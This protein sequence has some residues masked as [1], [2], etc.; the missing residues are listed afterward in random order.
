[1]LGFR[2]IQIKYLPRVRLPN[3]FSL[4]YLVNLEK[5]KS[6]TNLVE[7]NDEGLLVVSSHNSQLDNYR[8]AF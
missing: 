7:N 3:L 5:Y 1:M 8:G 2:I 4:E 6:C